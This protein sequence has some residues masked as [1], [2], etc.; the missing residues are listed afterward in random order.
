MSADNWK[1]SMNIELFFPFQEGCM[2]CIG[3][4]LLQGNLCCVCPLYRGV[5]GLEVSV[6]H[7]NTKRHDLNR[8][9]S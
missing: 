3:T 2:A 6:M 7:R 1:D 4:P 8:E 9:V 5:L